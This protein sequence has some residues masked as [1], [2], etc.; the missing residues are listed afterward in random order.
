MTDDLRIE[1]HFSLEARVGRGASGDVHRAKD[2]ETGALV[3]VKRLLPIHDDAAALERFRREARLLALVDDPHVVRYVAHGVDAEGRPCLVVEWLEGEDL[4]HRKRREPLLV[5]EALD[6]ARQAALGLH[7]LHHVGIVHRDVKPANLYLV[8]REGGGVVVK[9]I[10]LGVARSAGEATLTQVGMAIG[11]PFYMSPEQA[12]GEERPTHHADQFSLGVTIFE[13][14]AG[15]RPFTG[16]DYFAVLAK[17]V[18]QDPPHL[19]DVVPSVPAS[20]DALVRRM[21]CREPLD[22]F[23]SM[24]D[25]ADALASIAPWEP[26]AGA[27]EPAAPGAPAAIAEAPTTRMALSMSSTIEQRVVTALF[28]LAPPGLDDRDLAVLASL[29]EAQGATCHPTLGGRMIAVFGGDRT[30]GD[31]A[32][33][34]VRAALASAA[35]QPALRLA[36]V[37]G[38]TLAGTTGLAGDLLE[39]G[40]AE[41]E[42]DAPATTRGGAVRVDEAT[43]RLVAEHF[44]VEETEG[45]RVIAGARPEGVPLRLLVGKPTPC[46]GRD[47]E[48]ANLE[49]MYAECAAEPV[50]RAAVVVGPA[51][52]GKSRLRHE[53]GARLARADPRPLVFLAR[54][55]QLP[56]ASPFG[57]LAPALRRL[58]GVL[59]GEPA[60]SQHE[61]VA[62]RFGRLVS[63]DALARLGELAGLPPLDAEAGGRPRRDA[64]LTGDL[65]RAAW[66]SWL[67]AECAEQPV[68]LVLEDL[69][70]GDLPSVEFVGA[71]LRA[72]EQHPLLVVAL[73]RPELSERFPALWASLGAQEVRLS[74]LLHKASERLVRSALG[75]GV[76]DALVQRI[77]TRAE[78][79]AFYVEE[80]IRAAAEGA[81]EALP[82]SV[83]GMVQARLDV[84]GAET[85]RVL[86]AA[87]VFGTTFWRGGVASLLGETR[88]AIG[89]PL[90]RLAA[91]EI[92]S[93]RPT[94]SFPDEEEY[95]FRH[96]LVREAA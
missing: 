67:E 35:R 26:S 3:A 65:L 96:A 42:R 32:V 63:G 25:V 45:G 48:L 9:L 88:A 72:L 23:A 20:L 81:G 91:A 5:A 44:L 93:R 37:T 84:L 36:I 59:D 46:V 89:D 66:I 49:A 6:I 38:R 14:I 22:R 31:E 11:T 28:A 92:A 8:P 62:R 33:R 7:A 1:A 85:K 56:E 4:A 50:A 30:L 71:A 82:D 83:L 95:V 43:A 87:S 52:I 70:W 55:S 86:R 75:A 41:V 77:V 53:L 69:Q 13:L 68:A 34:A 12:R 24:R 39:R 90:A 18:L 60:A 58:A 16:D 54:P 64:M 78:G 27:A 15:R 80:L 21:M 2:R 73:G 17:I 79:N 94:A 19:R 57:L 76:D 10:D 61:K 74:P 51:G 40:A 29:A 47:R